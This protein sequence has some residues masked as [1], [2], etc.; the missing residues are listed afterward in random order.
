MVVGRQ[1][2]VDQT[3]GRSIFQSDG[4]YILFLPLRAE[5][6]RISPPTPPTNSADHDTCGVAPNNRIEGRTEIGSQ[7]D[8]AAACS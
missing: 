2:V 7:G 5:Y 6:R 1:V 4:W 3:M 8:D